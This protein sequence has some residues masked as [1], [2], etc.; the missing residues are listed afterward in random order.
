MRGTASEKKPI[1]FLKDFLFFIIGGALYAASVRI[2][3]APNQIA[4]GGVTGLS[5]V[6]NYLIGVP[7]GTLSFLLNIPIFV[8]AVIALGFKTVAKTIAATFLMSAAI[9][10]F[11]LLVPGTFSPYMGNPLLAAIC[12]GLL[13]GAGLSMVFLRGG[14]TGGSDM[15]ARL[16][17]ARVPHISMG[18]LI[19][20]VDC[21]VILISAF[22]YR[23]LESALYAG[24]TIFISSRVIDAILYGTD[25]GTGKFILIISEKNEEI[26]RDILGNIERGVTRLQAKGGYSGRNGEVLLGAVRRYEVAGVKEIIHAHDPA[27]FV[28]VG[29]AGEIRGEGFRRINAAAKGRKKKS[30]RA[31]R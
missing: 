30:T 15:V 13:E 6:I 21:V 24:I 18:Q 23:S 19:F 17:C 7:I 2:F 9:D 5:T 29:E 12:G 3:T 16:L 26:A 22:V 11:S 10:L 1:A 31:K 14:T 27:A 28:I 4:P 20:A 8:W 25:A